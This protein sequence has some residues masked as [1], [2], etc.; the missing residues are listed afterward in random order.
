MWEAD[1][2]LRYLGNCKRGEWE[3]SQKSLLLWKQMHDPDVATDAE[4]QT[5]THKISLQSSANLTNQL[6]AHGLAWSYV[7]DNGTQMYKIWA[8][9]EQERKETVDRVYAE[10]VDKLCAELGHR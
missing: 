9:V 4:R 6:V 10:T 2:A 5:E 1:E 3:K 8:N 7:N